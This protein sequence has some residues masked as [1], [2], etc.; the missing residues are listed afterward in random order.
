MKAITT[1]ATRY[2]ITLRVAA[3]IYTDIAVDESE[4]ANYKEAVETSPEGTVE[5]LSIESYEVE[6][7][8]GE[9]TLDK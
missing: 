8:T 3:T 7:H 9:W 6:A 2:N 1:T 5:I 4:L